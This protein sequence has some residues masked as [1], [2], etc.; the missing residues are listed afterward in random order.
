MG[1]VEMCVLLVIIGGY[2][3]Y[4]PVN[5]YKLMQGFAFEYTQEKVLNVSGTHTISWAKIAPHS[6]NY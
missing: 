6:R 4:V 2:Q 1:K 3:S 5:L